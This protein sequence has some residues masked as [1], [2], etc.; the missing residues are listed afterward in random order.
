VG[1]FDVFDRAVR[2]DGELFLAVLGIQSVDQDKRTAVGRFLGVPETTGCDTSL[3]RC[4]PRF[5]V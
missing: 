2:V 5:C 1:C 3:C 4:T